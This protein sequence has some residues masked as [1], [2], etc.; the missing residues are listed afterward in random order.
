MESNTL[1]HDARAIPVGREVEGYRIE[2]ILGQGAFGITY[3]AVDVVLNRK[4]AIKEYFP[5]E[6]AVREGSVLVKAAG[7]REERDT[8][9]WGL[10]RF[11][12][13]ARVLALF[14]HPNIVPIRRFFHSNDTAYLVMDYCV[15]T[16]LDEFIKVHGT[17]TEAEIKK[18]IGPILSALE[19]IHKSNFIHRDIKPANIFIKSDG[20]P[21][22][23][24]FGAARQDLVSHSK[25]VTSMVTEGY[26][27]FEQY[28]THG[29]LGPWSDIYGFAATLYRALTGER[30]L[31]AAS[32]MLKDSLEPLSKRLNG[33]FDPKLLVAIDAGLNVNPDNRPQNIPEWRRMFG[34]LEQAEATQVVISQNKPVKKPV[35]F[36]ADK[37][38]LKLDKKLVAGVM[39]VVVLILAVTIFALNNQVKKPETQPNPITPTAIPEKSS[40]VAPNPNGSNNGQAVTAAPVALPACQGPISGWNNCHG[41]QTFPTDANSKVTPSYVGEFRNGKPNGKGRLVN[42]VGAV[43]TGE[44]KDGLRSGFGTFVTDIGLRYSGYWLND[45]YQGTGTLTYPNGDQYVGQFNAGM[46]SGKGTYKWVNG[47]KYIG[48][49]ANDA[50]NGQGV[51]TYS[52]GRKYVGSFLNGKYSG[53]GSFYDA[54]GVLAYSGIW[55]D[56]KVKASAQSSTESSSSESA[57]QKCSTYAAA[58]KQ[59]AGLPKKIDNI[60]TSTDIFCINTPNKPTLVY[61]YNIDTELRLDQTNI[62]ATILAQ[63]KKLV[64]G[65]NLKPFLPVVDFEYQYYYGSSSNNFYPGK[66]VGKLHYSDSDCQ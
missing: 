25:S 26:G 37:P 15:G 14:D 34:I 30:P 62:D 54:N 56:G 31:D 59:K 55:E 42:A 63:N 17:F 50:M 49:Y 2:S 44:F 36:V 29:N 66:L 18:V 9:A 52:D 60:T 8:F 38:K 10:Q 47:Q 64:C 48:S 28:S 20:T 51:L 46:M 41:T 43:T 6:F 40:S 57:F 32:R 13:E 61:K 22:L 5:R 39:V 19:T 21:V 16:P 65:P 35:E 24:D 1:P 45:K 4:V 58:G 27:A 53:Q 7:T 12:E 3:L 23:L 33:Q 11:V